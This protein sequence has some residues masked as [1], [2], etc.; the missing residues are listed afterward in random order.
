MTWIDALTY[1]Q[2][3][4]GVAAIVGVIIFI[5]S[6]YIPGFVEQIG[7][8]KIKRLV[9]LALSMLIPV[10]ALLLEL[11]TVSY[12]TVTWS[13]IWTAMSTGLVSFSTATVVQTTTMKKQDS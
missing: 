9:V 10:S 13:A 5:A 4:L 2:S 3:D 8:R 7:N 6:E 11:F 12:Q 1:A